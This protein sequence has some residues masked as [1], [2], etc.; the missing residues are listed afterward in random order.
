MNTIHE[1]VKHVYSMEGFVNLRGNGIYFHTIHTCILYSVKMFLLLRPRWQYHMKKN[2]KANRSCITLFY[3]SYEI[4]F[5]KFRM[6]ENSI[7][8]V[9][10]DY[11]KKYSFI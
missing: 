10:I 8:S 11:L 5:E 3:E 1:F 2:L 7:S 9:I 6:I 4:L